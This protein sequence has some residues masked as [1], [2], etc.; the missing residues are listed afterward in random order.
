MSNFRCRTVKPEVSEWGE[1]M[2]DSPE[3]AAN[4]YHLR[5][6]DSLKNFRYWASTGPNAGHIVLFAL[7]E[8]EGHE[9]LISRVFSHGIHRRGGVKSNTPTLADIA[10]ELGWTGPPEELL[11]EDDGWTGV[12]T[13]TEALRRT[14][15]SI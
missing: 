13:M 7:V 9:T 3:D 14:D 4:S 2:A 15:R 6:S 8:V 10:R 12:E 1:I 5:E 11:D